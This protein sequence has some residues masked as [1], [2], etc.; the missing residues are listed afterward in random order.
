[1]YTEEEHRQLFKRFFG[2]DSKI[3][4][5]QLSFSYMMKNVGH[6]RWDKTDEFIVMKYDG[7][8]PYTKFMKILYGKDVHVYVNGGIL[9]ETMIH[10]HVPSSYEEMSIIC[11]LNGN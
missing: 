5:S 4:Q 3:W 6:F 7:D 8:K 9:N 2:N 10:Y 1:M 11:D